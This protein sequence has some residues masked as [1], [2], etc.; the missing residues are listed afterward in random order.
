MHTSFRPHLAFLV[1]VLVPGMSGRALAD[2]DGVVTPPVHVE[3]ARPGETT[4][5][6]AERALDDPAFV[7]VIHVDR[8][9]DETLSVAEVLAETVG[10]HVRS[11]GGLGSFASISMRGASAGQTEILIDGVPLSQVA[12]S[13]ID[14]GS[15]DLGT[16]DQVD[17]YRGGVP[18]ELGGAV[19]GG[20]VNFETAVG[21]RADGKQDEVTV[22]GGSFGAR[23]VRVSRGD[24]WFDGALK[25]TLAVGYSGT[26]GDFSYFDDNGT[27]LNQTD[28]STRER[29][30]NGYDQF[31]VVARV[32]GDGPL[33][34][35]A[36][37]RFSTKAQGV[38]GPTSVQALHANLSTTRNVVD[39][40]DSWRT[41]ALTVGAR[42]YFVV[43]AQRW[44]D[45]DGEVAP[46][47]TDDSYLTLSGGASL[48]GKWALSTHQQ[49]TSAL[50]GRW[51]HFT[52]V[53]NLVDVVRSD[54]D[55]HALRRRAVAR[56]RDR[57]RRRR[58]MGVHPG[59][60]RR[61]AHHARHRAAHA[62]RRSRADR[63]RRRPGLTSGRRALADHP[64]AHVEREHRALFSRA[65]GDR[66][67]RHARLRRRQPAV[68][69]P[70]TGT[71]GDH[72]VVFAPGS[73]GPVDHL[74]VEVAGFAT[75]AS[76]LIAFLPTSGNV[77]RAENLSDARMAG[78][79]SALSARAFGMLTLTGN[80][81]F[82][83]TE[84]LS[85]SVSIDGKQLPGRPRH[86]LYLRADV[87]RHVGKV[88]VGGF[89][90]VTLVSGNYLDVGN[91]DE[92][93]VRRFVGAGVRVAPWDGLA[94]TVE[95]KNLFDT[96]VETVASAVG[97]IPRAVA[98]V[99]DYPLPGRAF[100][101]AMDLNF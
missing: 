13:S 52:Q 63:S 21:P 69:L 83:A 61:S 92:V 10:V 77:A 62:D 19:L 55:R 17:V 45:P 42:G 56:R 3:A 101:A 94:V 71:S 39:L 95:V 35:T 34:L 65:D 4:S 86:S 24:S 73:V 80:Y 99:L 6:D 8:R 57:P 43:E 67:L 18:V 85:P 23:R 11:L 53:N 49:L 59:A 26:T 48:D 82:L 68:S 88:E 31:D 60:A 47:I 46:G 30:N 20:A 58:S 54:R 90:D 2:D 15:L 91:L 93:P 5:A 9:R 25:S 97:P 74:Y 98:D 87:A 40:G 7:T 28:D 12:F 16:F 81:T 44:R 38:A 89:A 64:R 37:E 14:V 70:E 76:N 100:Y 33:G 27:P 29:Q 1:I 79:E 36:G 96:T 50:D 78:V 32:A 22:G 72:G 51:E 41:G 75:A 84:Q 66:A